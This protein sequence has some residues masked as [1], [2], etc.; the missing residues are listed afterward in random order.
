MMLITCDLVHRDGHRDPHQI[1][2]PIDNSEFRTPVQNYSSTVSVGKRV[3][4]KMA[5]NLVEK[6][7]GVDTT[8]LAFIS[9][10]QVK[11]LQTMIQDGKADLRRFCAHFRINK[12]EELSVQDYKAAVRDLQEKVDRRRAEAEAQK[13]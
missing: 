12:L 2:L 11:D 7:E 6:G 10:E 9:P 3:L 4:V 1:R 13:P 5:L 8:H